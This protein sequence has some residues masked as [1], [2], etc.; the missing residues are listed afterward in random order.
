MKCGYTN[1]EPG[2]TIFYATIQGPYN[3]Q[4][5]GGG[6]LQTKPEARSARGLV[7]AKV[8]FDQL[9]LPLLVEG[10]DTL[11]GNLTGAC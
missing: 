3:C 8:G 10:Q 1:K 2:G 6:L 9:F 11:T 5:Y 4:C 7:L